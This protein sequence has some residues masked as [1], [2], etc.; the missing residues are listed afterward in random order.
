MHV[1]M[2]VCMY[3]FRPHD[4]AVAWFWCQTKRKQTEPVAGFTLNGNPK[5]VFVVFLKLCFRLRNTLFSYSP[6]VSA[7][8]LFHSCAFNLPFNSFKILTG[9][10]IFI[11]LF[12][13]VLF[14]CLEKFIVRW[15]FLF[16]ILYYKECLWL[17]QAQLNGF[18]YY[19]LFRLRE[20]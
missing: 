11:Y 9:I 6:W 7:L 17:K 19:F 15:F 13:L 2:Y 20:K 18:L 12:S 16:W 3:I 10:Y 4:V 8:F 1:C 14:G 5:T